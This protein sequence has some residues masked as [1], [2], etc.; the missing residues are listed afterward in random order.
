MRERGG[1]EAMRETERG[2][3]YF[4]LRFQNRQ[5]CQLNLSTRHVVVLM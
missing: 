1:G 5:V 3:K 4:F 2:P